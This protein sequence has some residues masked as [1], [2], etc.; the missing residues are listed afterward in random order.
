MCLIKPHYRNAHWVCGHFRRDKWIEEHF[1]SGSF[2]NGH[3]Q[4]Q[5]DF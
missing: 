1:R 2:V 3:C 5:F 4:L